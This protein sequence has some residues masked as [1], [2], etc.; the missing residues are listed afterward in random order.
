V[1]DLPL[2]SFSNS[3]DPSSELAERLHDFPVLICQFAVLSL[4]AIDSIL[5]RRDVFRRLT[6]GTSRIQDFTQLGPVSM[7]NP[8]IAAHGTIKARSLDRH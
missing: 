5:E 3:G 8:N 2:A 1:S 6:R 4:Q 7:S